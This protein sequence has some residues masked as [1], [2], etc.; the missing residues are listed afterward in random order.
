MNRKERLAKFE[1]IDIY[2]VTCQQL[3]KGRE[4]LEVLNGVFR[5][6]AR[7]V[8]LREKLWTKKDIYDLALE[9]R[10]RTT[11]YGALLI[12]N[13]HVD[14]ALAVEADGV[15]LGHEDL[16][17]SA[18]R[19]TAP[20]ILLGASCHSLEDAM[21]A[22]KED[23][24]YVNLGPI[25]STKTKDGLSRFLGPAFIREVGPKLRIPFTV[26][27]GIH[28]GNIQQVLKAGARRVAMVTGITCAQD[29]AEEVKNLR[30]DILS[31]I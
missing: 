20:E 28:K 18:A 14:V 13:D 23:V 9:F 30:G 22:Q 3:S 12:I 27:G 10:E 11:R 1:E 15:H 25:F 4:N 8:Q 24:D 31:Y 7:I 2:P 6:G 17:I 5:G 26:M 16:P 19:R 29:I 21:R